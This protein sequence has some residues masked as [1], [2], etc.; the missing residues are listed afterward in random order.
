MIMRA[1]VKLLTLLL[2]SAALCYAPTSASAQT[3]DAPAKAAEPKAE[4]KKGNGSKQQT[5]PFKGQLKSLDKNAKTIT[6]GERVFQIT[7]VT[8]IFKDGKPALLESG[9][10]GEP[11]TGS[12][13]QGADGKLSAVSVYFGTRPEAKGAEKK[14]SDA[15]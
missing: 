2:V 12:Y 14:K 3:N 15:Q 6:V 1:L 4:K 10:A 5:L 9:T 8:R 13:R 7:S 11:I